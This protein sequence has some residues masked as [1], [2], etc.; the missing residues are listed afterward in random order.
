[1]LI[2]YKDLH[3][4]RHGPRHF[5]A[6]YPRE[7]AKETLFINFEDGSSPLQMCNIPTIDEARLRAYSNNTADFIVYALL[8]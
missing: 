1:M 2:K 4:M 3:A 6:D 7:G 8:Y 5:Y